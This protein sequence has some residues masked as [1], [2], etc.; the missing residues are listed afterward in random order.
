MSHWEE[1]FPV[2]SLAIRLYH[3]SFLAVL[4]DYIMC[5]EDQPEVIDERT[6]IDK[7]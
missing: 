6:V 5:L 1:R 2:L 7:F 3:I 4:L